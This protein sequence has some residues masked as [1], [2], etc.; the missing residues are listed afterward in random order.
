MAIVRSAGIERLYFGVQQLG[1]CFLGLALLI[2]VLCG[3]AQAQSMVGVAKAASAE[4][5]S[6]AKPVT[7][8]ENLTPAMVREIVSQM[9]DE[10]VR[11]LLL[12]RLD[13]VAAAD[14]EKNK[15]PEQNSA[16]M[17]YDSFGK[18]GAN[19]INSV[20]RIPSSTVDLGKAIGNFVEERGGSGVFHLL[21]LVVGAIAAGLVAEFIVDRLASNW[22]KQYEHQQQ[23]ENLRQTLEFL[24]KRLVVD[25][26]GLLA[27]FIVGR[28]VIQQF[29]ADQDR[30]VVHAFMLY[31]IVVPRVVA[32]VSRFVLAPNRPNMRLVYADDWTSKFIYYNALGVVILAGFNIFLVEFLRT[33]GQAPFG[34]AFIFWINLGVFVWLGVMTYKARRGL[35][36]MLL[37]DTEDVTGSEVMTAR[38]F[39]WVAIAL[40]ALTWLTVQFLAINGRLDLVEKGQHY[41]TLAL[42]LIAPALNTTIRGLVHHLVP[43]MRGEGAVAEAAYHSTKR[44]Y[45]RIGRTL[46]FGIVIVLLIRIWDIQLGTLATAGLGA[47][48]ASSFFEALFILIAGY[49]A[50]EVASLWI[51]RKLA[52][53]N[54]ATAGAPDEAGGEGG[55]A[56]GSRL[57]T[58]LPLAKLAIQITIITITVLIALSSFG[59]NIAPLLAGAGILGLAIGFGAQTLV[60]DIVS[61]VFF[62]MDDAFR[63]GEF[64]DINGTMGTVE[65]ISIRSLQLRHPSG[66]VH[67]VPYGE[68][69]KITNNSRDWVIMKV[70]FTVPFDTDANKV[71]KLFKQI[72][73]DMLE[74]PY[75]EDIIQTFKSQG[76]SD[77]NDV[78]MVVRG[79]F[80]AKPGKQWVIRKDVYARVQKAFAE[81]GIEFARPE[82]RVNVP[83]AVDADDASDPAVIAAAGKAVKQ[84][85]EAKASEAKP[86]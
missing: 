49:L 53:E 50:W 63:V 66:P 52:D 36:K 32:A 33:N 21:L 67:T 45:I 56:G 42:L 70:K 60:K 72:G 28:I 54:T 71:K 26:V 9:D 1:A 23:P 24:G 84:M 75:A 62:L 82:V 13:A 68:I 4:K 20:V 2:F 58:V 38:A 57:S 19:L 31:L 29:I 79:K 17:L 73:K 30:P 85:A 10:Q 77:V 83:G 16:I 51:N 12:Q 25:M 8:P 59:V 15:A 80:M 27:F 35:S 14:A 39:P 65:K 64:L 11:Q 81:N 74:A 44:S 55:G 86:A 6:E 47:R 46:V 78:G 18:L 69:P 41:L 61:G 37:G 76:V 5:S 7:L 22:R 48:I 40:I 3:A 34:N 43:P